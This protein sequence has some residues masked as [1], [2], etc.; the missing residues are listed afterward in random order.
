MLAV[1]HPQ[2]LSKKPSIFRRLSRW[3]K[4]DYPD[5]TAHLRPTSED[6]RSVT[7]KLHRHRTEASGCSSATPVLRRQYTATE[8]QPPKAKSPQIIIQHVELPRKPR[9]AISAPTYYDATELPR[10]VLPS[11]LPSIMPFSGEHSIRS[12]NVSLTPSQASLLYLGFAPQDM[13]DKWFIYSEGPDRSGRLKVHFHRSWTGMKI[14]QLF[15]VMDIKGEGAGKIVGIKWNASQDT[16]C[17]NEEEA[18][19]MVR[20]ICMWTMGVDLEQANSA[21]M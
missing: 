14:A 17:M 10:R 13:S 15:I 1:H 6:D 19:Y 12:W 18:K 11:A 8:Y 16:N 9:T 2:S 20:M 21:P 3:G 4:E 7:R 5:A